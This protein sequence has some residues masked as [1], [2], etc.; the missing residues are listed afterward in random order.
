MSTQLPSLLRAEVLKQRTTRMVPI[1][2]ASSLGFALFLLTQI[3]TN[4][5]VRGAPSL[6]QRH[7]RHALS[8]NAPR[9][10]RRDYC[11]SP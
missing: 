5:G 1:T 8:R 4:A 6:A 2:L 3:I 11:G 9:R 10:R 7:R